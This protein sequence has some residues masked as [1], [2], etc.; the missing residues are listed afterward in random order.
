LKKYTL[1]ETASLI[2]AVT[3]N[4][5]PMIGVVVS[6]LS[7][8]IIGVAAYAGRTKNIIPMKRR[9]KPHMRGRYFTPLY[10]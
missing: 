10:N 4:A 8:S 3:V 5:S 9:R 2:D 6:T 7:G 1:V